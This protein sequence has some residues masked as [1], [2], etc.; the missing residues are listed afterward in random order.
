MTFKVCMKTVNEFYVSNI[1]KWLN[2]R[3]RK[4]SGCS[5]LNFKY[6]ACFEQGS[7]WH[8]DNYR[9]CILS[10]APMWHN[11]NTQLKDFLPLY[12]VLLIY[13]IYNKVKASEILHVRTTPV[14]PSKNWI[15]A[16][17]IL[18]RKTF[19]VLHIYFHAYLTD[20]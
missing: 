10:K 8:L 6:R 16:I 15:K 17:S 5:Y 20:S 1:A 13:L 11:K 3:F 7:P 12:S 14:A 2:V 18:I 19:P 4:A 9:M